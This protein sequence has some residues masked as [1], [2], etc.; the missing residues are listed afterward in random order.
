MSS[1]NRLV[2][3]FLRA[4]RGKLESAVQGSEA[5]DEASPDLNVCNAGFIPSA[6]I[7]DQNAPPR[8][9]RAS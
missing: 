4:L 5:R 6:A 3:G 7:D 9:T 1:K 8:A 2:D